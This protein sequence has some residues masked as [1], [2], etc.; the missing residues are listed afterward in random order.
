MK[1]KLSSVFDNL[2]FQQDLNAPTSW[3]MT[4]YHY[5][6]NIFLITRAVPIRIEGN[7]N[8]MH[9]LHYPYAPSSTLLWAF[10]SV[11]LYFLI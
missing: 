1:A 8:F 11:E 3:Q 9:M 2:F 10:H 4:L 5:K 6:Y 7:L